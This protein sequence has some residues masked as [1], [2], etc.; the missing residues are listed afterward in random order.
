MKTTKGILWIA[1]L[2]VLAIF[3]YSFFSGKGT[4]TITSPLDNTV[5][6]LDEV[7]YKTLKAGETVT[8]KTEEGSHA[9][10][11]ARDGY[12][13]W[14]KTVTVENGTRINLTPFMLSASPSGEIITGA[15]PEH[16]KIVSLVQKNSLPI[17]E[18][19][20]KSETGNVSIW[21]AGNAIY[22]NWTGD[23]KNAPE[24]FCTKDPCDPVIEVFRGAESVENLDFYK[25]REDILL[26]AAGNGVFAIE[27]DP[28][29]TKNF[30]PVF[31][32]VRPHFF[33]PGE[34]SIYI[35]DEKHLEE[36]TL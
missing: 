12:F 7:T 14:T 21:A 6:F 11:T 2:V 17:R 9:I 19:P 32:G 10:L 23:I 30:Q 13:P 27:T 26:F 4:I 18:S 33:K 5:V 34:N 3:A 29:G 24:Y 8:I 25:N 36:I 31:T 28:R 16:D 35:L 1:I 20:K 15:D 22:A